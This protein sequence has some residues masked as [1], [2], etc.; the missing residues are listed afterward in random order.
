M[1]EEQRSDAC[2]ASPEQSAR[3]NDERVM[4]E[5]RRRSRRAFI[6]GGVAALA[7]YGGWRW[8]LSRPEE[9][10][11]LAPLRRVLELNRDL[12]EGYF[13]DAHLA[14][15]F[16]RSRA[17]MPRVNGNIGLGSALDPAAWRLRALGPRDGA[18]APGILVTMEEIRALPRVEMV[19]ELKCIEGWSVVVAWAGARLADFAERYRLATRGGGPLS[20]GGTGDLARYVAIETPDRE[21][22]VGLDIA[23]TLHPQTLLCYEMNGAP[24]TPEHG[25]PLR[26]ATPVKYG[27]KSIKRIGTIRFTDQQPAD[28]W[29]REGY[30][31][32]AGL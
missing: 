10:G 9:D 4:M 26:L 23:S 21:Y 7:G 24:L 19:T 22:F 30:D 25:A 2:P 16:P 5:M 29:A 27:I 13:S 28:Y 6:T 32:Y 1:S 8:L 17:A 15:T 20:P 3:E 11:A 18:G 12:A 31:W 14:P